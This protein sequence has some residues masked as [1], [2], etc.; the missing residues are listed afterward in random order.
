MYRKE[1]HGSLMGLEHASA[2]LRAN[3][4]GDPHVRAFPVYLPPGYDDGAAPTH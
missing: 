1:L 4:L 3:P 2:L